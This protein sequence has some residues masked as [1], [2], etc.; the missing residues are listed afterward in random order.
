MADAVED[1]AAFRARCEE[2][3]H[4]NSKLRKRLAQLDGLVQAAVDE[5]S[6]DG[7]PPSELTWRVLSRLSLVE[8]RLE[9]ADRSDRTNAV[10]RL[11]RVTP[12][13]T[14][15]DSDALFSHLAELVGNLAPTGAT[16][17][18]T[19]LEARLQGHRFFQA[20]GAPVPQVSPAPA[21]LRKSPSRSAGVPAKA[22]RESHDRWPACALL[23]GT[24]Q[25][26]MSDGTLV[27]RKDSAL[28]GID[29]DSGRKWQIGTFSVGAPA[30]GGGFAYVSGLRNRALVLDLRT[31]ENRHLAP[32]IQ[33]APGRAT[34]DKGTLYAAD[35]QG[36]LHAVAPP[37]RDAFWSAEGTSL[38][39]I[40]APQ[41]C[42]TSVFA[43]GSIRIS[44]DTLL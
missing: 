3:L 29:T 20:P 35:P 25:P 22:R 14:P 34:F 18:L 7:V 6:G 31:G 32:E 26:L 8:L 44:V 23:P 10:E 36:R 19:G 24:S 30:L 16:V 41:V 42:G 43:L 33:M 4:P 15:E 9:E 28:F 2:Q 21:S 40:A 12:T 27:V 1:N 37:G 13:G 11:Q 39:F 5:G 38:P 17:S